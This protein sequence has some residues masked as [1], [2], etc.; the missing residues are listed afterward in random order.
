MNRALHSQLS[1]ISSDFN[2]KVLEFGICHLEFQR[3]YSIKDIVQSRIQW[4]LPQ[5]RGF[6]QSEN[7]I[8]ILYRLSGCAFHQVVDG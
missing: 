7:N 2:L 4:Y 8:H 6:N 5:S 1:I 3:R